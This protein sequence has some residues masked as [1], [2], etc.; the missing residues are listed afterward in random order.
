MAGYFIH[1]LNAEVFQ[2][3]VTAPTIQQCL[4]LA[5]GLLEG[6]EDALGEY[7]DDLAADPNKWPTDRE[8]LAKS[9]QNRLAS[10]DWY[11]DFSFGDAVIWGSVLGAL[12]DEP[13]EQFGIGFQN[14]NDGMLYWDAA[15]MAAEH[16]AT[17]MAEEK[18]GRGGF[19]NNGKSGTDLELMDTF[20]LPGEVQK[21]LSQLEKVRPH[22]D[23]LRGE[24]DEPD[25]EEYE[26]FFQGL[27]EPVRKIAD[28]GRVMWVQID[29]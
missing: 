4:V 27:L 10:P 11:A 19:R 25:P 9:I 3:L 8:A 29:T 14:E 28:Q 24:D 20:Y 22:F 13:G 23:A 6:L 7:G 18:F 17:M 5:D 15:E 16:G 26:Q 12:Q 21:L 1:S 2:Q